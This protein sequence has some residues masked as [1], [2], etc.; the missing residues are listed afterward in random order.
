MATMARYANGK[1]I[2]GRNREHRAGTGLL[3]E[4]GMK[5]CLQRT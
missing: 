5:I 2:Y 1:I 4:I 3:T